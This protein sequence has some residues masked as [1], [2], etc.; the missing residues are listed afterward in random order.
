MGGKIG[1]MCVTLMKTV[2]CLFS[3][4]RYLKRSVL[5]KHCETNALLIFRM[6]GWMIILP[7]HGDLCMVEHFRLVVLNCGEFVHAQILV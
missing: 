7:L 2:G 4:C 6:H 3:Y 1:I 5:A